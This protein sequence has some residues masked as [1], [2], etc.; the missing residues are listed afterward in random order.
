[1]SAAPMTLTLTGPVVLDLGRGVK[2]RVEPIVD[3]VGPAAPGP[4]PVNAA[5]AVRGKMAELTAFGSSAPAHWN[6]PPSGGSP[7]VQWFRSAWCEPQGHRH[8]TITET[9]CMIQALA[10]LRGEDPALRER[11]LAVGMPRAPPSGGEPPRRVTK[12]RGP[13]APV[14]GHH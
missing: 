13:P 3:D 14:G 11:L 4:A 1:M 10:A 8:T 7:D 2:L 5:A 6:E 12:A 9:G